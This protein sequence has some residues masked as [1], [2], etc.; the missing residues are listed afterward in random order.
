MELNLT[1]ICKRHKVR[2]NGIVHLGAHLG[3][4]QE[5]YR[6]LF[7]DQRIVWIEADPVVYAR[8]K[9]SMEQEAKVTCINAVVSD[10]RET[11]TFN[12][13]NNEQS[14]SLLPFGTHSIVHPNVEFVDSFSVE[15]VTLDDLAKTFDF[16]GFNFL[17]LDIQGAEGKAISGAKQFLKQVDYIY[18]E[19]NRD[20]LYTGCTT[21]VAFD[22][23]LWN[24]GFVRVELS[25]REVH[26][27]GDAFYVRRTA[28]TLARLRVRQL[29]SYVKSLSP[30]SLFQRFQHA[31]CGSTGVSPVL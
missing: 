20:E 18:S 24:L 5:L 9:D 28:A 16:E 10:V 7:P 26:G 13:A 17:L 21:L 11:V 15:T 6:R 30:K 2:A 27:W 19:V 31:R 1:D 3:Q 12:R 25:M 22:E 8:L 4:E 23:I 14:S 29:W